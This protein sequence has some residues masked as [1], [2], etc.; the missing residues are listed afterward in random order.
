MY[1][2]VSVVVF[3]RFFCCWVWFNFF[4]CYGDDFLLGFWGVVIFLG[5][6][7]GFGFFGFVVLI[8]FFW[9][10]FSFSVFSF[11]FWCFVYRFLGVIFLW[12]GVGFGGFFGVFYFGVVC[13]G[14]FE[15]DGGEICGIGVGCGFFYFVGLGISC[16]FLI[17]WRLRLVF[18]QFFI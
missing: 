11:L 12:F 2:V 18:F 8:D 6:C 15:M 4:C 16:C 14:R 3:L 7:V 9:C 5:C 1:W 13:V 17:C 10:W